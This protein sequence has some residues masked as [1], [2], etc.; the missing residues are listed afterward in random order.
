[1]YKE[2]QD[3]DLRWASEVESV[4][5]R[6]TDRLATLDMLVMFAKELRRR[7]EMDVV[8]YDLDHED[9]HFE[10]SFLWD[11][12]TVGRKLLPVVRAITQSS[13]REITAS[14]QG[15]DVLRVSVEVKEGSYKGLI[16]RYNKPAPTTGDCKVEEVEYPAT[17][18]FE[19]VCNK[20]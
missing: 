10:I 5:R 17:T 4:A 3:V 13:F 19:L 15:L 1:M 14:P 8:S 11:G 18:R 2:L 9:Y 7:V 12:I 20:D 6:M 16:V